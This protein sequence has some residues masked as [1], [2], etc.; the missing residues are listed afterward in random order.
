MTSEP[1]RR[2]YEWKSLFLKHLEDM[3]LSEEP[4]NCCRWENEQEDESGMFLKAVSRG[5]PIL[6]KNGAMNSRGLKVPVLPAEV[7]VQQVDLLLQ[8]MANPAA[9]IVT[10]SSR[11]QPDQQVNG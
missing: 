8:H 4:W 11:L 2:A 6:W 10:K 5:Q 1:S 3:P 9:K 7:F